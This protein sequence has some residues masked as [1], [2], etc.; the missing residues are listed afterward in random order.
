MLSIETV[1][2]LLVVSALVAIA[3]R[4][5]RLPYTVGLVVA[6]AGLST[7]GVMHEF[8]L[9]KELIVRSL[10]PPLIFEAAFFIRWKDL[11][12]DLVPVLSLAIVGVVIAAFVVAGALHVVSGWPLPIALLLGV[13]ISA[14][15]P[16]SVVAMFKELGLGGRLRLLVEA[17]SLLND[18]VVAVLF[19][20]LL[21]S[22]GGKEV[23]AGLLGMS[24]LREVGGGILAGGVVAG[25]ALLM[26][27]RTDD[28]L[29]ELTIAAVAAFGSYLVA[30]QFHCSGVLA[31]LVAGLV[32]GNLDQFGGLSD[33]GR[34]AMAAF[35]EFAAFLANSIIFVLIGVREYAQGAGLLLHWTVVSVAVAASLFGRALAVYGITGLFGK[36]RFKLDRPQQHILFWG[37][38]K[39]ALSLALAIGLPAEFPYR[40]QIVTSAF[41]VVGFSVIVQGISMP[42]LIGRLI[43]A[44]QPK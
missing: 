36:S 23:G 10:L 18:G 33:H 38:L 41:G 44:T 31:V 1:E 40:E 16:V 28:H 2:I 13:L 4:R 11:K 34:D 27:G 21:L 29:V 15:D 17:E 7:F 8:P 32:I 19:S 22:V 42:S 30:E 9:T 37:G 5:L 14:T 3:S 25:L 24:L 26:A 35:W 39:G 43:P 12:A 20:V 6:G